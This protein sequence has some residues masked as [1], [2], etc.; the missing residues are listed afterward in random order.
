[1]GE[2]T[3]LKGLAGFLNHHHSHSSTPSVWMDVKVVNSLV[4]HLE[5]LKTAWSLQAALPVST[6][7]H[8]W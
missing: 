8:R 2:S 3:D 6:V 1:M 5:P 7:F 4:R